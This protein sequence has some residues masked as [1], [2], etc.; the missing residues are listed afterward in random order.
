VLRDGTGYQQLTAGNG[1]S[2]D[3]SFTPDGIRVVYRA[4]GA[5]LYVV[6]ASGSGSSGSLPVSGQ[7]NSLSVAAVPA[8]GVGGYRFAGADGSVYSYGSDCGYGSVT[9]KP[10]NNPVVGMA[11]TPDGGGYW[12]VASDGG[13]FS[14]GDARF[15]G[16]TGGLVLNKPV[17]EVAAT[18]GG[19][20]Y[21]LVASD[22]GV[23]TF[24]DAGFFGSTGSESISASVVSV[25]P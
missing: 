23:F 19:G 5:G 6:N 1:G 14:F 12:L 7:V 4:D 13:V 11:S 17:V 10:L 2:G 18:P 8:G 22:G 24:G 21:W 16:S 9:G 25:T 3:V 15:H 20:G